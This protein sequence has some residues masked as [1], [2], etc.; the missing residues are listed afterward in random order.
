MINLTDKV[1]GLALQEISK[2]GD[3]SCN[4]GCCNK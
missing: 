2:P 3:G 1:R 4:E